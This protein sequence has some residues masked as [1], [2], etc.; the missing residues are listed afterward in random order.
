MVK[1]NPVFV[2]GKII[3]IKIILVS[4]A[5]FYKLISVQWF[6]ASLLWHWC[7]KLAWSNSIWAR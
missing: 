4:I 1:K 5:Y 2:L 7:F 6:S 3:L